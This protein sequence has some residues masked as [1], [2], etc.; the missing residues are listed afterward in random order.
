MKKIRREYS[1]SDSYMLETSSALQALFEDSVA[2]F[3]NLDSTLD[4]AFATDWKA[5]IDAAY[6]VVQHSQVKD[7]AAQK[8]EDVLAIMEKCRLKYNE[9]KFFIGKAFKDYLRKQ[10]QFGIDT[11]N[12]I[13][14]KNAA[15]IIFMDEMSKAAATYETELLAVGMSA[16]SIA[17]IVSL[18]DDLLNANTEQE[19]YFK[20]TRVITQER[21]D[22]LN[23]CYIDTRTVIDAAMVVYYNDYARRSNY[24]Y[25]PSSSGKNDIEYVNQAVLD[26]T[27]ILIYTIDY[28]EQRAYVLKNSGPGTVIFY[29]SPTSADIGKKILVT[30]GESVKAKAIDLGDEGSNLY[31]RLSINSG[32]FADIE[33]EI[34]LEQI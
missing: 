34:S 5:K 17:E 4:A 20:E 18:R 13:R 7:I 10:E 25:L 23:A 31:V 6:T 15:M 8:T 33:V 27:P 21:I 3:T 2:D 9:V 30:A 16:A 22:V 29:I 14:S 24:V 11:Y 1:G 12:K 28:V 19:R 26:E 32:E